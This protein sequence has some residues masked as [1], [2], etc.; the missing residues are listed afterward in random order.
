MIGYL[1]LLIMVALTSMAQ[2]FIKRASHHLVL[3]GGIRGF[4]S[5]LLSI[6]NL[7][8]GT[9][10]LLAPVFYILALRHLPL[11]T[12][13]VFS[14]LNVVAVTLIGH[15]A[16]REPLPKTRIA[17]IVLIVSGILCFAL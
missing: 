12:A 14:S 11:S 16:F 3:N 1:F 6:N 10:T 9:L 4:I 2:F 17:G 7:I 13:Y 5:S 8:G 15:F